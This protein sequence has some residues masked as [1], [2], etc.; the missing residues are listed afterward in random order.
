MLPPKGLTIIFC[1]QRQSKKGLNFPK[2]Q[3]FFAQT[4][5]FTG[6]LIMNYENINNQ[7][8]VFPKYTKSSDIIILPKI[9]LHKTPQMLQMAFSSDR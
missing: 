1:G 9:I 3:P 8:R 4:T 2:V 7:K 5:K 6:T